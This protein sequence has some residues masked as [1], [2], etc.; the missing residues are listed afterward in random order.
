MKEKQPVMQLRRVKKYFHIRRRLRLRALNDINF[1]LYEG[2][3]FGVVGES[4]CGK[5]TLGRVMLQLYPPSGGDCLYYGRSLIELCPAYLK[6]EIKGLLALQRTAKVYNDRLL[7]AAKG[8]PEI[9][10]RARKLNHR[11]LREG[12]KTVGSLILSENLPEI[13]RLFL[14][15]CQAVRRAHKLF[16]AA[17]RLEARAEKREKA[18]RDLPGFPRQKAEVFRASARQYAEEAEAL[19]EKAFSFR[20]KNINPALSPRALDPEYQAK[21]DANYET[22][23]SLSK[24]TGWEMR[25]LRS[26]MQMV[27]QDPSASL[28][29]RQ[30]VGKAIEEPFKIHARL[31]PEER[32]KKVMALLDRV[33]LQ[34]EHYYYFPNALSGGQ[35]QRVCI[36]RAIATNTRLVVLDESLSALDV[37][38][39]AQILQLLDELSGDGR[40]Y[41]FITHDLGVAK[42]F[43]DR[44]MVMYLGCECELADARTLFEKP[45]HPYTRSLLAAVPRPVVRDVDYEVSVLEGEVPNA[46]YPPAGC[47]FHTRCDRSFEICKREKPE[48]REWQSGHFVACHLYGPPEA[49]SPLAEKTE[50]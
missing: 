50:T 29:P 37:S 20:G 4:G 24:L 2:E 46:L 10:E 3:K 9:Y 25:S 14:R 11:A 19:R 45:L 6:R 7:A 28:D 33:G 21:L 23:I 35:K 12:S 44:I 16:S 47:P 31:S 42:Y 34:E 38:V 49:N 27:F 13:Q 8:P 26:E 5:S 15:A 43:C 36:A 40:T 1:V 22:G 17:A 41:L 48:L 18:G 30:S 32:K 39:Q